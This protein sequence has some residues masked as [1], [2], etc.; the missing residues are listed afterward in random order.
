MSAPRRPTSA[1]K[2]FFREEA[3]VYKDQAT[4]A[5]AFDLG[6][7]SF[8]CTQGTTSNGQTLQLS[9]P[10]DVSSDLAVTK[11]F[12]ISYRLGT[13]SGELIAVLVDDRIISFQFEASTSARPDTK[14]PDALSVAKQGLTEL[15]P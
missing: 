5:R 9:P 12:S 15:A 14:L 7:Q 3:T 11:A 4:G 10:K 2:A 6:T 8:A 1:S 13:T